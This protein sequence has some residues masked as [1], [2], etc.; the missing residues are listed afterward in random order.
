MSKTCMHGSMCT[1]IPDYYWS[2]ILIL[3]GE[4][5]S[6]TQGEVTL[7][8]MLIIRKVNKD[9]TEFCGIF[10]QSCVESYLL[11]H[12][13]VLPL[14]QTSHIFPPVRSTTIMCDYHCRLVYSHSQI[15]FQLYILFIP[16]L[17]SKSLS[18]ATSPFFQY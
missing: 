13:K 3:S 16:C 6:V 15:T 5:E 18:H 8:F 2:G 1:Y 9:I 10:N 7:Y 4:T 17:A 11:L 12:L 14:N